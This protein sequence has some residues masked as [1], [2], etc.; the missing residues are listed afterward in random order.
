MSALNA[1]LAGAVAFGYAVG[2]LFF[3]RF[4]FRTGDRLFVA[5][6]VAFALL[7]LGK[8]PVALAADAGND[9]RY[10]VVRLIAFCILALAI[11]DKNRRRSR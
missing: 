10:F 11:L 6:A 8:I 7:A 4:W 9:S 5:F 2:A 3:L 1:F